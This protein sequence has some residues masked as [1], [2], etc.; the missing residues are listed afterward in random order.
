MR[1]L[2]SALFVKSAGMMLLLL[3]IGAL[4][5]DAGQL[6]AWQALNQNRGG[7]SSRCS[8]WNDP[9]N[10]C[11]SYVQCTSDK[12]QLTVIKLFSCSLSGKFVVSELEGEAML[13]SLFLVANQYLA[14]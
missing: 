6:Q 11:R 12:K 1:F 5:L 4:G 13:S 14:T 3:A 10:T 7:C 8:D 2:T 9:C